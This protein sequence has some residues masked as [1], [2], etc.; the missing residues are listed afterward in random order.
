[1]GCNAKLESAVPT[2]PRYS[3]AAKSATQL[4]TIIST[5]YLLSSCFVL[6]SADGVQN[7]RDLSNCCRP[8]TNVQC[9]S[10]W[11]DQTTEFPTRNH[12]GCAVRSND[13]LRR[14][15]MYR[16]QPQMLPNRLSNAAKRRARSSV[17]KLD[18]ALW[19][20]HWLCFEPLVPCSLDLSRGLEHSAHRMLPATAWISLFGWW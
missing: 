20:L 15:G 9:P 12:A 8:V 2:Y 5:N 16:R 7:V 19:K 10:H 13:R 3:R 14:V 11:P 17:G 6:S 1:M 4:T 18:Q